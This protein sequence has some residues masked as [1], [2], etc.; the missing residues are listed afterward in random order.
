[1][2]EQLLDHQAQS[3][4][5]ASHTH[6]AAMPH[7]DRSS[8]YDQPHGSVGQHGSRR[9]RS[10]RKYVGSRAVPRVAK[11]HG[12]DG[13]MED[14]R[15]PDAHAG[16]HAVTPATPCR[17]K[18]FLVDQRK[19]DELLANVAHVVKPTT[20]TT[21]TLRAGTAAA[22]AAAATAGREA[23]CACSSSPPPTPTNPAL[24]HVLRLAGMYRASPMVCVYT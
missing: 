11:H 8:P 3:I 9:R 7:V 24:A 15:Q 5:R 13:G 10:Q 22:A 16:H 14:V 4:D 17:R 20:T 1:V 18:P 19:V 21:T 6:D 12:V 2:P 23:K